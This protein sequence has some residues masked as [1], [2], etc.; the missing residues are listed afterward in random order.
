MKSLKICV[1]PCWNIRVIRVP[2]L[3]RISYTL[4]NK[5]YRLYGDFISSIKF[6]NDIAKLN[7]PLRKR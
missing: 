2:K 4:R 7:N 3:M 1:N 5:I 6:C